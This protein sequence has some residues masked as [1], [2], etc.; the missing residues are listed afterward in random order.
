MKKD[1]LNESLVCESLNI[2]ARSFD[3]ILKELERL[4][5]LHWFRGRSPIKTLELAVKETHAWTLF[6]ILEVLHE[7]A[8][9][10]WTRYG[11]MRR[12]EEGKPSRLKRPPSK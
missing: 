3:E 12:M 6:E 2:V 7:R 10:E 5:Q 8:E 9:V 11:R 4:Q 1:K